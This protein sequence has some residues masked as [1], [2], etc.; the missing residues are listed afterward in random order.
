MPSE[1]VPRRR[2]DGSGRDGYIHFDNGG[3]CHD[4][5]PGNFG[6]ELRAYKIINK[7]RF[8]K[9]RMEFDDYQTWFDKRASNSKAE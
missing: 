5:K 2:A 7:P 4:Y 1:H 8:G 6:Q 9:H 3:L